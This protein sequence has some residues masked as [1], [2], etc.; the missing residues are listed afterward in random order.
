M[1]VSPCLRDRRMSRFY[2]NQE[3]VCFQ[4]IAVPEAGMCMQLGPARNNDRWLQDGVL[5]GPPASTSE[6]PH[7]NSGAWTAL[8][9]LS[10]QSASECARREGLI[11]VKIPI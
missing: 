5:P 10:W 4:T 11:L 1:T 7:G 9:T 6:A 2:F 3:R 8:T